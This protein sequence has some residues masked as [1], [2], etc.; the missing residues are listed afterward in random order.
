MGVGGHVLF[1]QVMNGL[2]L[3]GIYAL[4]ALGYTMVYG[5]LRMINFAHSE[6]FML[7]AVGG[8]G[9]LALWPG[10]ASMGFIVFVFITVMLGSGLLGILLHRIAYAPL[11]GSPRL[12]P[13][14]SAIGASL[15]LQNLVFLW[16]DSQ[17]AFPPVFS[18]GH[19][20]WGDL[21]I[22]VLQTVIVFISVGLMGVLTLFIRKTRLGKAMRAVSQDA[23][24]AG[25]MGIPVNRIIGLTFFIGAALGGAAGILNG[26]YY[27]SVKY[28][29]GFTPGLKAFT[30]AVLGGIGSVPGAMLG[31]FLLGMVESLGA[32]FLPKPEWKDVLAFIVL[33]VVLLFR[34][35]G[36]LGK[37]GIEKV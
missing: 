5:V 36:L 28:N 24:T 26:L 18:W 17:L 31:G 11:Q 37:N 35:C 1:E 30:A 25:L 7:G 20:R 33:I 14:L 19:F 6:L 10:T 27:G 22:N 8:W 9:L 2:A 4:I 23:E 34:P 13:L 29:M 32:G 3:G 15:V 12:T 16:R 21:E